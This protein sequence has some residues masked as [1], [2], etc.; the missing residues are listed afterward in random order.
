[1]KSSSNALQGVALLVLIGL[2]A[3]L[4]MA[5][6]S[7]RFV[8]RAN[9][10][11]RTLSHAS[12][13]VFN[14]HIWLDAAADHLDTRL[15]NV[16]LSPEQ[17]REL[18]NWFEEEATEP[19]DTWVT[20]LLE[21]DLPRSIREL[22]KS[23]FIGKLL[24]G[25]IGRTIE[26]SVRTAYTE[27]FQ[28]R[29]Q[30]AVREIA[31]RVVRFFN[32]WLQRPETRDR[33]REG[34]REQV[35]RLKDSSR[36]VGANALIAEVFERQGCPHET[37]SGLYSAEERGMCASVLSNDVQRMSSVTRSWVLLTLFLV[38]LALVLRIRLDEAWG[39]RMLVGA[40]ASLWLGGILLPMLS[41]LA[42]IERLELVIGG[43]PIVFDDNVLF[44]QEK[45]I[46]E[47]VWTLVEGG[48][49]ETAFVGVLV[50]TFSVI[51]P[52]LKLIGGRWNQR[53]G[54]ALRSQGFDTFLRHANRWSM[55]DVFVVALFMGYLGFEQL[56]GNQ[57]AGLEDGG[58]IQKVMTT[59]GT[60][61]ESG[62]LFFLLFC[63]VGIATGKQPEERRP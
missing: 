19:I 10:D 58:G 44:Y 28:P 2:F 31:Q 9:Q 4:S 3:S 5:V 22:E 45:S 42:Q 61:L 27:T 53:P 40:T 1:M 34:L 51:L 13:G 57:L 52:A 6:D 59:N 8:S 33:L 43:V 15:Q 55:A 25:G 63:V 20:T 49:L 48:T 23:P 18:E 47:F 14:P 46:L 37:E 39:N 30:Q 56:I 60:S 50:A 41:V 12:F 26:S 62:F 16:E 38:G 11:L 54:G 7:S 29:L 17:I 32:T 21:E 35:Q 24:A 36:V